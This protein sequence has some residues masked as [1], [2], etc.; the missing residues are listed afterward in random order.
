MSFIWKRELKKY[1]SGLFGWSLSVVMLLAIGVLTTVL[2]LYSGSGDL[3]GT[4]T[5]LSELMIVLVPCLAAFTFTADRA[6]GNLSWLGSLLVRGAA[7]IVGKYLAMLT[8][9]M[10]PTALLAVLPPILANFGSLSYASVYTALLG[11]VLLLAAHTAVCG[12]VAMRTKHTVL[13]VVLNILLSAVIYL[14]PLLTTVIRILPIVAYLLGI[15]VALGLGLWQL[16]GKKRLLCGILTV[17]IPAALLSA[18]FFL[19]PEAYSVFLA[20]IL[21]KL[22]LFELHNGFSAG[23]IDLPAVI[24]DLSITAIFLYLTV[25]SFSASG[26]RGDGVLAGLFSALRQRTA[27]IATGVLAGLLLLNACVGFFPYRLQ[28]IETTGSTT[29]KL[30]DN[31]RSYLSG[32]AEPVEITYFISGGKRNADRDIYSFLLRFADASPMITV[33]VEDSD[34]TNGA[35]SQTVTVS[36]ARQSRTLSVTDLYFYYNS[37][38]GLQMSFLEYAAVR[39]SIA[40]ITD[41][42]EYQAAMAIYSPA[43]TSAYFQGDSELVGAVR[44][45]LSKNTPTLYAYGHLHTTLRSYLERSG[46]RIQ[47]WDGNAN[48]PYGCAALLI[49]ANEDLSEAGAAALSAYLSDGGKLL[50]STTYDQLNLPRL[51]SVLSTYGLSAP[52]EQHM[53]YSVSDSQPSPA[54]SLLGGEH[55]VND[56]LSADSLLGYYAHAIQLTETADV[57]Q[58]VLLKSSQSSYLV[59]DDSEKEPVTGVNHPI[60]VEAMRGESR[61]IWLAMRNDLYTHSY[62]GGANTAYTGYLIN[63]LVGFEGTPMSIQSRALPVTYLAAGS[64]ALVI[65]LILLAIVLPLGVLASGIIRLYIRRKR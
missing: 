47:A 14:L 26:K 9:L 46:Y 58:T 35:V 65:W 42:A 12:F 43:Y 27:A 4:L 60:C 39:E 59:Y 53:L 11:Y 62:S 49:G 54:V 22:S 34:M 50:L 45:V 18:L 13:S 36:A 51:Q 25:Y 8:L 37:Q 5:L 32:I 52:Q 1:F 64:T 20:A 15:A 33:R 24:A 31:S 6:N 63:D 30:S 48:L 38:M 44:Q 41:P 29:Y 7:V 16:L 28:Y 2:N 56:K 55:P 19:L 23:H 61:V 21:D 57:T 3:S 17:L 10:I 40:G